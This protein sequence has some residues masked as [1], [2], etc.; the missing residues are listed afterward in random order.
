MICAFSWVVVFEAVTV[1]YFHLFAAFGLMIGNCPNDNFTTSFTH[2]TDDIQNIPASF[3][4]G[5]WNLHIH[6]VVFWSSDWEYWLG[7]I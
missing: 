7:Q 6:E 5:V 1:R 4:R 3:Q 2:S